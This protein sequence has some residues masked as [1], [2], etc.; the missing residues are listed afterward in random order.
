[1][2]SIAAID[3][4]H[5]A[6]PD[7]ALDH[8]RQRVDVPLPAERALRI[9]EDG[10]RRGCTR[11]AERVAR[12]RHP[13]EGGLRSRGR[14]RRRGRR[15][16][17]RGRVLA[18]SGH[19]DDDATTTTAAAPERRRAGAGG[20][21]SRHQHAQTSGARLRSWRCCR[22]RSSRPAISRAA[23]TGC[24]RSSTSYASAPRR[25]P[26]AAASGRSSG[27]A[28]AGSC[29]PASGST[30]WSIPARRSSS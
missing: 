3:E 4:L 23:R 1:M 5:A 22:A 29:S 24:K 14:L 17:L 15:R 6:G 25:S 27:I 26:P 20:C 19:E 11:V 13:G 10:E 30:G 16:L 2:I 12:L 21:V 9:L 8:R 28:R 7:V 18:R